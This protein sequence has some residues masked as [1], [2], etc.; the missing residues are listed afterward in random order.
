[1]KSKHNDKSFHEHL[2]DYARA[3]PRMMVASNYC[4]WLLMAVVAVVT[5][6][7]LTRYSN[8]VPGGVIEVALEACHDNKGVNYL[9]AFEVSKGNWKVV[10]EDGKSMTAF[11]F[12]H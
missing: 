8:Y 12:V 9:D 4:L 5:V 3:N 10:C 11:Y 2:V 7:L 6:F 1:M